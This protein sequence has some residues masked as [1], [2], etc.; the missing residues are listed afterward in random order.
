MKSENRQGVK[1]Y[2]CGNGVMLGGTSEWNGKFVLTTDYQKLEQEN[3]WS[4]SKADE[5]IAELEEELENWR[6]ARG[7][8]VLERDTLIDDVGWLREENAR[9]R[10]ALEER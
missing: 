8:W 3:V 10:E 6:N 5:R 1:R 9:L 7:D 4:E 2:D